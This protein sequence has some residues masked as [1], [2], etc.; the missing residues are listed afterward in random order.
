MAIRCAQYQL[1]CTVLRCAITSYWCMP[2]GDLDQGYK[3]GNSLSWQ[4]YYTIQWG[5]SIMLKIK[6]TDPE[7]CRQKMFD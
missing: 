2:L 7:D 3:V 5:P 1:H 4:T 6:T